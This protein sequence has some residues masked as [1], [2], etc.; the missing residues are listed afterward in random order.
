MRLL[1]QREREG[2]GCLTCFELGAFR[3]MLESV[4][5]VELLLR[6]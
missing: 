3:E 6:S 1:L 4:Q 2:N 5:A